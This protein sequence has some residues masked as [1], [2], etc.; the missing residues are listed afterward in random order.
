[1]QLGIYIFFVQPILNI[2][3]ALDL[4]INV[5]E[6]LQSETQGLTCCLFLNIVTKV[7]MF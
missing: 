3:L 7:T 6:I 5:D 1:M 2:T 4:K